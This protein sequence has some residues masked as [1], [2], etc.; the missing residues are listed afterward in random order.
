MVKIH[1]FCPLCKKKVVVYVD[2]SL[3]KNSKH[4]PVTIV[5][6]DI[7][8][9][10]IP[11][12]HLLYVDANLQSRGVSPA[13]L[14]MPVFFDFKY[15][16]AETNV[17]EGLFFEIIDFSEKIVDSRLMAPLSAEK[18]TF[19]IL[20]K[21][22]DVNILTMRTLDKYYTLLLLSKEEASTFDF[23]FTISSLP[24]KKKKSKSG[25]GLFVY[26]VAHNDK[27]AAFFSLDK[28]K[29]NKDAVSL[30]IE[31]YFPQVPT[32]ALKLAVNYVLSSQRI[33]PEYLE[34]L[35]K[36]NSKIEHINF[37]ALL[38][39]YLVPSRFKKLI[40]QLIDYSKQ[41][42]LW[43]TSIGDIVKTL[44]LDPLEFSKLLFYLS[45]FNLV[46]IKG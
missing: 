11:H 16:P 21:A 8:T 44:N 33:F 34:Y 14:G 20:E 37:S 30:L 19:T 27:L 18:T 24:S 40:S 46:E 25:E 43:G 29:L 45:T 3:I 31:R 26:V 9:I 10:G 2:E 5:S 32:E 39:H 28:L 6:N 36:W 35:F 4:Y 15:I 42:S 13:Y 7:S 17:R 12:R 41:G 1:D 38:N 22:L 23:S